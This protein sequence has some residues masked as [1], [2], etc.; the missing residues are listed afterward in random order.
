MIEQMDA[1]VN[2]FVQLIAKCDIACF[3]GIAK[4]LKIEIAT[5]P[6]GM[7]KENCKEEDIEMRE[8]SVVLEEIIEK[9][10]SLGR[11]QRRQ[12]TQVVK[13]ATSADKVVKKHGKRKK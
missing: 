7:L 3:L 4:I 6:E 9:F 13:A 2:S 5:I 11:E 10:S 12:L 1:S 8:F